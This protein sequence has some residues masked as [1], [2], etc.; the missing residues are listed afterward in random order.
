[1]LKIKFTEFEYTSSA[2]SFSV[3]GEIYTTNNTSLPHICEAATALFVNEAK[4]EAALKKQA[5]EKLMGCEVFD[6]DFKTFA[7][8]NDKMY[9][10]MVNRSIGFT[11]CIKVNKKR[12]AKFKGHAC[13]IQD[14]TPLFAT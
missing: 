2:Q 9:M 1:M 7:V 13:N 11:E 14:T 8:F 6:G 10:F 4:E 3:A 5:L 12:P